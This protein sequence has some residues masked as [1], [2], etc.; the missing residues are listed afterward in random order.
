MG[1]HSNDFR[2]FNFFNPLLFKKPVKV[3]V[4]VHLTYIIIYIL[5]I[6]YVLKRNHAN[7]Q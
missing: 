6:I 1:Y 5:Y 7:T 4:K 3:Y 2:D